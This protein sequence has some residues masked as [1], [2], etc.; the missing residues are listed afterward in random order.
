[1]KSLTRNEQLHVDSIRELRESPLFDVQVDEQGDIWFPLAEF[2][3]LSESKAEWEDVRLGDT[4]KECALR[5]EYLTCK[6]TYADSERQLYGEFHLPHFYQALIGVPPRHNDLA[7]EEE[8]ALLAGLRMIDS[9]PVRATG[10][11]AFVRI[12]QHKDPLDI[13]YQDR[14]LFDAQNNSQGFVKMEL[15]YCGYLDALRLTKGAFGWQL[16]FVDASLQGSGFR[17]H[18]E[19][20]TTM[21]EVFPAAFPQYDYGPLIGRLEARL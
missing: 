9:A 17:P 18:R 21:L 5:F 15:S 1:M 6:W 11:A 12:E 19:N 13:W 14:Y 20:L 7:T 8:T 10:E 3:P 16:L 4:L 2:E